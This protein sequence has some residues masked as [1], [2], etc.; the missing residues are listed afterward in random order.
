MLTKGLDNYPGT[1][2]N[3]TI[4][5]S[6]DT[7]SPELNTA[8][9]IDTINGG[10]GIDT[11]K[12]SAATA[13][14]TANLPTIS[15]VEIIEVA[16]A[17]AATLDT[18]AI[19]GLTNL[20]VTKAG[21][22]LGLT[23]A[24]TTAVNVAGATN[25][26]TVAGGST[27]TVTVDQG[28]AITL[29]KGTDVTV[30]TTKVE[31]GDTI[32]IG[33]GTAANNPSGNV[34]INSTGK[35]FADAT[36][37]VALG[38]IT[39]NGGKTV[40][41]TQ[42]AFADTT[43]AA[44]AAAKTITQSAITVNG[45]AN[46]TT[47][48]LKQDA[49]VTAV[50]ATAAVAGTTETASVVFSTMKSGQTLATN[51]L[52]FTASKDLT[53]AEV[54]LAFSGL[55]AGDTMGNG[56]S[57][58]GYYSGT[59][60]GWTSGTANGSTVVFTTTQKDVSGVA[61]ANVTDLSFTGTAATAPVA[62]QVAPAVTVVQGVDKTTG[63]TGVAGVIGGAMVVNAGT[64]DKITT[65]TLDG[66]GAASTVA[67]EA[68]STLN[69]ANSAQGVTVTNATAGS[70][71]NLGLNKVGTVAVKAATTPTVVAAVAEAAAAVKLDGAAGTYTTLNVTTSG[72]DSVV[73]LTASGVKTLNVAGT[74]AVKVTTDLG[75]L[76]KVTVTGSAGVD[77]SATTAAGYV[78][79]DTTGT[80]GTV[81]SL[82]D[83]T[84]TYAGGAGVDNV[85]VDATTKALTMGAGND[86]VT[87][88]VAV[89]ANGS[90]DAGA[91]TDVLAMTAVNAIAR[92]AD[93]AFEA[94]IS[95]FEVLQVTTA[96]AV[97]AQTINLA[98]LDDINS[99]I[100]NG[101]DA[102]LTVDKFGANGSLT[103]TGAL[104]AAT[105]AKLTDA[106]GTADVFNITISGE[107]SINNTGALTVAGVETINITSTDTRANDI[108]AGVK[109]I[110]AHTLTLVD[111]KAK[112]INIT[113]N[114]A[115][116]LTN[117]ATNVEVTLI[118]GSAMTGALTAAST[119][120]TAAQTIKGGSGND[121]LTGGAMADVLIGGAGNDT[122]KSGSGLNT[123]TGG[124]GADVF[125][126]DAASL[127]VNSYSTIT[128]F[129]NLKDEIRFVGA[130]SFASSKVTLGA[131]AVFQ[132]YAN[133]AMNAVGSGALSWFQYGGDTYILMDAGADSTTFVNGTDKIV[134]LT[135]LVDLSL[136]PFSNTTGGLIGTVS[137]TL[138]NTMDAASATAVDASQVTTIT[139][140]LA[141]INTAI[142]SA[143]ITKPAAY[144]VTLSDTT[145]TL[146]ALK[147]LSTTGAITLLTDASTVTSTSGVVADAKQMLVTDAGTSGD[148]IKMNAAVV[149]TLSDANATN[150]LATDLSAIGGATT[151]TV[152][153]SNAINITGTTAEAKAALVTAASK[154]V[155]ATATV[156][157]TDANATNLLATD[158]SAIGGV[159]SGAVSVNITSANVVNITGTS[160][161]ATAALVT[162]GSLVVVDDAT[163]ALSDTGTVDIKV[164]NDLNGKTT[165]AI[166]A[167]S[168]TVISDTTGVGTIDLTAAGITYHATA[169]LSIVGGAGADTITLRAGAGSLDTVV[170]DS[171]ATFDSITGFVVADDTVAL[172]KAAMA[173]LGAVGALT[174][175]EFRADT[176]GAANDAAQRIIYDTDDG[177][178]YYDADGNGAGAAVQIA[179]LVGAPSVTV[180]DFVI[181]A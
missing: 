22:A 39:V 160:A 60:S 33:D 66:Y 84:T 143:G 34:T 114:A 105:E 69:L 179:T 126:I 134:K 6:I 124:E 115:L 110:A 150:I 175:A 171:I 2:G 21:G 12:F 89:G 23:A 138:L 172:S 38:A 16:A 75:A 40:S 158:L 109:A 78:S 20:N 91:G 144:G 95:N 48:T 31:N 79:I 136:M 159:T 70:T 68:L 135:G 106:T 155:A 11:F 43:G 44:T 177:N 62:P 5:G 73:A 46:T 132:D 173:A 80:T 30:T 180:A 98:N 17:A 36:N 13:L 167:T 1:A 53:A 123:L 10:A 54:A 50:P 65:V 42:K 145:A 137:A 4:I 29:T 148:K 170:L 99:V 174:A 28:G 113:G 176:S 156:D 169:A 146:T 121:V 165:G 162:A 64:A 14:T 120:T 63:V 154:V 107:E 26:V 96:N 116:N 87:M 129:E 61:G 77:L 139:G 97:A 140:A 7:A 81:T 37:G 118:D 181:V 19:A 168:V 163:V 104:T 125:V 67:S 122:L 100:L 85:T 45:D 57:G 88:S 90:V 58:L 93:A 92:S 149:V 55:T 3:D 47:V 142:G 8:S 25:T 157:I 161:E 15:N 117:D 74:N 153:A 82:I 130:T 127:N 151:G 51:G 108:E 83:T 24:S 166:S 56:G 101:N 112:T 71:L 41:V 72:A 111:T 103:L 35:A 152:T 119:N 141:D 52:T 102:T 49:A 131:T 27:Q 86:V 32:T 164:L 9:P 128:D 59:L 76:E 178:L 133:A 18:S 147:T 94:G